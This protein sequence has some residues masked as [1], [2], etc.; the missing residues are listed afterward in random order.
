[1]SEA[2]DWITCDLG[3]APDYC[4]DYSSDDRMTWEQELTWL[5]TIST[6]T[7]GHGSGMTMHSNDSG[8]ED[9]DASS[10]SPLS[11]SLDNSSFSLDFLLE[12]TQLVEGELD[13]NHV[14]PHVPDTC[15]Y[16]TIC[17]NNNQYKVGNLVKQE[18]TESLLSSS[19]DCLSDL[20]WS[21]QTLVTG[22][23]AGD[24]AEHGHGDTTGPIQVLGVNLEALMA[25]IEDSE[26][27]TAVESI[28]NIS[29]IKQELEM[30]DPVRHFENSFPL[31]RRR[32]RLLSGDPQPLP[33]HHMDCHDYIKRVGASKRSYSESQQTSEGDSAKKQGE[34]NSKKGKVN[35]NDKDYLAH[36]TGIPRRNAPAKTHIKDEDKIYQCE[37]QGCGKL[38][39]KASHLKAHMRRHTGEKPFTCSWPGCGWKF[40]RSDEL[41]RHRRSH[42]GIKPYRCTICGK[43]FARSDHLDKHH[44]IHDR[45]RCHN[46]V[47]AVKRQR[48]YLST[49]GAMTLV[50]HIV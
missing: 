12:S 9:S 47:P 15:L 11:H 21:G 42:S 46:Y 45:D 17:D 34:N 25:P 39:A 16:N 2:L 38:Y 7:P 33:S 13:L 22:Q 43:R 50:K 23:P 37:H 6:I 20:D 35:I 14:S 36:G 30:V 5:D 3:S 40:S 28:T 41:A 32:Q 44:K 1:M 24:W 8:Y 48:S 49:S 4:T 27:E 10:F 31:Q 29:M 18:S 26:T 19:S